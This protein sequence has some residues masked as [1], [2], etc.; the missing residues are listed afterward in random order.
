MHVLTTK[1]KW[2]LQDLLKDWAS[3]QTNNETMI[4]GLSINSRYTQTGDLFLAMQGLHS[5]GLEFAA[6]AVANGAV[7]IAW[8]KN[9]RETKANINPVDDLILDIDE[10]IKCVPISNLQQHASA[11]AQRFYH[12]P[13]E[14]LNVI[15]VTGTDGKTSVSQF[16]AQTLANLNESCAVIGT[17]GYGMYPNLEPATHTTP[18]TIRVQALLHDFVQHE[19]KHT[20][21][22]ASSHGLSQGRLN[23]V[24][25]DTA[26]FTNLGRDHMDYHLTHKDYGKAK[27]ILF[28]MPKLK[29]AVINIDDEFGQRLANEFAE[30]VN[31]I[32]YTTQKNQHHEYS[33]LGSY[34]FAKNIVVEN[35]VTHIE[36]DSSWGEASVQIHLLGAFNVSNAM[37][38]IGALLVSGCKFEE[39]I[40]VI[41]LLHTVAGRMQ[42]IVNDKPNLPTVIIDYAHTPQALQNVLRSLQEHCAAKLWCVFGCGGDRDRGKRALM[43]QAV[44]K[45][46]NYAIVTDDNPRTE[47][48]EEITKQIIAGFSAQASY[49]LIH[50]R[51]EAIEY[52]IQQANAKDIIL[53]AGKGHEAVQIVNHERLPFDDKEIASAYL[54]K[55]KK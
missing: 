41:P 30:Q 26:V 48:P 27:R 10:E 52:A 5:H 23:N 8:E 1:N 44:E 51:K 24:E 19:A 53:I 49:T 50:D 3:I 54:Q 2:P 45:A 14:K 17:L 34:I 6:Q 47:N 55:C 35:G 33:K 16:I 21:V 40:K 18:D 4:T 15:G 42:A 7:A 29:N 43:A 32:T 36:L 37:A 13:S 12:R 31:L 9:T 11:I 39:I 38:T 25:I 28:A 20:V 46:A 22:E